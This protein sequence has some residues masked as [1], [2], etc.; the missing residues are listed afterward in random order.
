MSPCH[1]KPSPSPARQK[2]LEWQRT[3][4][5]ASHVCR[6]A[7]QG[8]GEQ[9]RAYRHVTLHCCQQ[10]GRTSV[11]WPT[12]TRAWHLSQPIQFLQLSCV[13]AFALSLL[14]LEGCWA[15]LPCARKELLRGAR[16]K[17]APGRRCVCASAAQLEGASQPRAAC[18][19]GQR[20]ARW[21]EHASALASPAAGDIS[22][23]IDKRGHC[24]I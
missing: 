22:S 2:A 23:N 21:R 6:Q 15:A 10:Q 12:S 4:T 1:T 24:K 18:L 5:A 9:S 19:P 11:V 3:K 17:F 8:D 14:R 20:P 7:A 16:H 13:F